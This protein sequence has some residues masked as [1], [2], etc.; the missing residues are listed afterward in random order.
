MVWTWPVLFTRIRLW[1]TPRNHFCQNQRGKPQTGAQAQSHPQSLETTPSLWCLP[2]LKITPYTMSQ[3]APQPHKVWCS[4]DCFIILHN[5]LW[6]GS[7][8][9]CLCLTCNWDEAGSSHYMGDFYMICDQEIIP[10]FVTRSRSL[11]SLTYLWQKNDKWQDLTFSKPLTF[12]W[13]W[14]CT[15]CM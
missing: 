5:I 12:H 10:V 1:P 8:P 14:K 11:L 9:T 6:V 13:H 4:K 15:F 3:N 2:L 7:L